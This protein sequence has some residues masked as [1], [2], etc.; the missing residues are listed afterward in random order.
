MCGSVRYS[1]P[2]RLRRPAG[3][4]ITFTGPGRVE[5][6]QERFRRA[7][8]REVVLDARCSLVSTGTERRALERDFAPGGHWDSWVRY[9]FRPGYSFVGVTAEGV[10]M[11][12]DAPHAQRAVVG[13]Q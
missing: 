2:V 13:E 9:P 10:R 1:R 12:A 4:A 5:V 6:R 11:C 8:R 7:R 3:L